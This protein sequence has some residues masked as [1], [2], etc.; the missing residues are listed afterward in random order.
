MQKAYL[1]LCAALLL[2]GCDKMDSMMGGNK[3]ADNQKILNSLDGPKVPTVQGAMTDTAKNAEAA[4]DFK[5]AAVL[6]RQILDK[7]PEDQ[8]AA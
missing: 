1:V 8:S 4:G 5:Q 3:S 7:H 6:Y 2:A